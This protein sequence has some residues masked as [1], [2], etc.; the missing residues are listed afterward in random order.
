MSTAASLTP[1]AELPVRRLTDTDRP[2]LTELAAD[3]GWLGESGRWR[4]LLA[5]SEAY[6]VDDPAG[7]LAGVV[8]LTRYG[9]TLAAVGMMVV[10]SRHSRQGLARRLMRH[11]L[12]LAEDATVYLT[13]TDQGRPLYDQLGF[14]AVDSSVTYRGMF[15]PDSAAA[16]T[17]G[18]PMRPV[19][20]ADLDA[21]AAADARVF[22]ADRRHVLA[23]LVTFADSF[24][25][26]GNPADGY[27]A[28]W[29][30]DGTRVIG[31][32]VAA[33]LGAAT[34]L[35]AR[36]SA[37]WQGPVRLDIL[38]R[39]Q[40]LADWALSRGLARGDTTALM[41]YGGD[42]PGDRARLYGPVTVAIG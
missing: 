5:V 23:E 9:S 6:G 40:E 8:V 2:A 42:L 39:H 7:G 31:P 36:L 35:I 30:K 27:A 41:T 34:R 17:P 26:L 32:I 28:A 29:T 10:A 37:G 4:L 11:V 22:G 13:A 25:M 19:T 38:G 21:L 12:A 16:G 33:D 24:L 1:V 20:A 3:R 15:A 14:R 18:G